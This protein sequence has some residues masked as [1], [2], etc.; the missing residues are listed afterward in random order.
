MSQ[1]KDTNYNIPVFIAQPEKIDNLYNTFL[2]DKKDKLYELKDI[3]V[4][5]MY[6]YEVF[7]NY[8]K[9]Y[10]LLIFFFIIIILIFYIIYK[11]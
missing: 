10:G 11:K 5:K 9:N 4:T 2:N 6:D 7:T 8:N 1:D 3:S